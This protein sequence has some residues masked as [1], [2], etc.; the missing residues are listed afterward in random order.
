LDLHINASE[1]KANR[2]RKREEHTG[3]KS[4][5]FLLVAAVA[6]MSSTSVAS[7]KG[8]RKK[9]QTQINLNPPDFQQVNL[10]RP[11]ALPSRLRR[12]ATAP[13]PRASCLTSAD[14]P[15]S[16]S[17]RKHKGTQVMAESTRG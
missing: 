8:K 16:R 2:K 14:T 11:S 5:F 1:V 15:L 12:H 10:Q 13:Y 7:W 17:S 4:V 9:S 3:Q 6:D